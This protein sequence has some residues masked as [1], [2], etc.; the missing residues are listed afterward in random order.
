MIRFGSL[1]FPMLPPARM[2]VPP[3][4]EPSQAFLLGSL[5]FIADRL[6]ILH[7]RKETLVPTLV[8]GVP[9]IGFRTHDDFND[10]SFALHSK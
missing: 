8:G 3:I 5:D 6:S 7:L 9:S 10:E 4:F 1:E 2:W